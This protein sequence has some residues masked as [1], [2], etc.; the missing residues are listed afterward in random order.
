V[1]G[2]AG[3]FVP[4]TLSIEQHW[5][6]AKEYQ[7]D[8]HR[9]C[10]W[11]QPEVSGTVV[12]HRYCHELFTGNKSKEER[13]MKKHLI[14]MVALTSVLLFTGVASA[15]LIVNGGFETGDFTGWTLTG[16]TGFTGV[17]AGNPNSGIYAAFLGSVGSDGYMLQSASFSTIVGEVYNVNFWLFSDGGIPNDFGA[18]YIGGTPVTLVALTNI[19][20]QPYTLYQGQVTATLTSGNIAFNFRNDPGFLWLDD[21][22][23]QVPEPGTLILLGSGLLGLAIAGTRKKFRK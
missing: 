18:V 14:L 1:P 6:I 2:G 21:V 19:P 8:A 22:S 17:S 9:K 16:N 3:R 10:L 7:L 12:A 13:G 11:R 4:Q 23:V 15:N 5:E 20:A